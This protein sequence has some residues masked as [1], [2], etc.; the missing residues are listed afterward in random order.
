MG[1]PGAAVFFTRQKHQ[2]PDATSRWERVTAHGRPRSHAGGLFC[3]LDVSCSPHSSSCSSL[4]MFE[5]TGCPAPPRSHG[6]AVPGKTFTRQPGGELGLRSSLPRC[7]VLSFGGR[8]AGNLP[9]RL[10]SDR[11]SHGSPVRG[12]AETAPQAL[13]PATAAPVTAT[14]SPPSALS[15]VE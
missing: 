14:V 13:R 3:S 5:E 7:P 8:G 6:L 15:L 2:S 10:V 1:A 9:L 12:Q 4:C 11:Q